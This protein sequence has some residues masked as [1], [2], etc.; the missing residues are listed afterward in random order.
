MITSNS[1]GGDVSL[2][3]RGESTLLVPYIREGSVFI[4]MLECFHPDLNRL[5][6]LFD[7]YSYLRPNDLL[8]E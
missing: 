1:V 2:L 3:H 8:I 6:H 5:L 4:P 7:L